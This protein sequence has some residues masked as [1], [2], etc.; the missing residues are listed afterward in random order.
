M[1]SMYCFRGL[2]RFRLPSTYPSTTVLVIRQP[3]SLQR[4][5]KYDSLLLRTCPSNSRILSRYCR[6]QLAAFFPSNLYVILVV[7]NTGTLALFQIMILLLTT[8]MTRSCSGSKHTPIHLYRVCNNLCARALSQCLSS[9]SKT[10]TIACE[11]K[12]RKCEAK[13]TKKYTKFM[14]R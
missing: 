14:K 8:M 13:C 11:S 4:S 9:C 1:L 7:Y 6:I 2:P 5:P 3:W 10:R 12:F